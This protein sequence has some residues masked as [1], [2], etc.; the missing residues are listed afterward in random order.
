[1]EALYVAKY[2]L[3]KCTDD[4]HSISNLQLQKILYYVQ[5]EFLTKY[6]KP[7]FDDDFEAWKFGPVIPAVYYNYT[8][9][10]ALKII[11][12]ENPNSFDLLEY[13]QKEAINTVVETQRSKYPWDLVSQTHKDGKA[14]DK[15]F[16]N[17]AGLGDII[18]KEEIKANAF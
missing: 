3:A 17:G 8:G 10:G 11:S 9:G 5:Y 18:S 4:S 16:A 6:D 1:M 7:L 13:R 12:K 2:I 15:V 14:W